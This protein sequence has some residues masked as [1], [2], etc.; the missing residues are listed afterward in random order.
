MGAPLDFQLERLEIAPATGRQLPAYRSTGPLPSTVFHYLPAIRSTGP[1]RK[2]GR[3][4]PAP[5]VREVPGQLTVKP[6]D[7]TSCS[8]VTIDSRTTLR[9]A[10]GPRMTISVA[11]NAIAFLTSG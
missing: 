10:S 8:F 11:W 6:S 2:K 1:V 7:F 3:V 4:Q 5:A 9:N